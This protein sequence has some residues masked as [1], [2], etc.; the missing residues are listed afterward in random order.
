MAGTLLTSTLT[1]L[2]LTTTRMPPSSGELLF[3]QIGKRKRPASKI[4]TDLTQRT[5]FVDSAKLLQSKTNSTHQTHQISPVS[6]V[7]DL[8]I[9][10]ESA[11]S[12]YVQRPNPPQQLQQ[13]CH[14]HNLNLEG[15]EQVEYNLVYNSYEYEQNVESVKGRLKNHI[16]FWKTKL[17]PTELVL[18]TIEFGYVIPFFQ[19]PVSALLKNNWS[20]IDNFDFVVKAISEL[21]IN[22]CIIETKDVPYVVNPLTVAISDS[23]KER[24]VSDLRHVNRYIEKQKVKFKGTNEAKQYAKQGNYAVKFDLKSGII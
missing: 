6:T 7:R 9:L 20:A 21:L 11:H 18:H 3:G 24:L 19:E 13:P 22:G 16:N 17:K 5:F 23:G 1:I 14:Q 2:W 12:S 8:D 15:S 4:Q 10:Q